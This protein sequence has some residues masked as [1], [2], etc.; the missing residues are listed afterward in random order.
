MEAEVE[1]DKELE[2]IQNQRE[3]LDRLSE[4]WGVGP[5]KATFNFQTVSMILGAGREL[6]RNM[7]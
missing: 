7:N 6:F 2:T 1:H 5:N 3:K 4:F